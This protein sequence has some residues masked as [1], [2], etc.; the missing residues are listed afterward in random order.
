MEEILKEIAAWVVSG[1]GAGYL[2]YLLIN[3]F[4]ESLEPERTKRRVAFGL[5]AG[6]AAAFAG[7][8]VW[9]GYIPTPETAQG[10]VGIIGSA[11][12]VAFGMSQFVHGERDLGR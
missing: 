6:I 5:T 4:G 9:M 10:W 11:W 2:A 8:S 7:F 3:E 12:A 1:P